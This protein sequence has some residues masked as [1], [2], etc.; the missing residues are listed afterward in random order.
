MLRLRLWLF[1]GVSVVLLVICAPAQA[2][3][4]NE[5]Q[6]A[7]TVDDMGVSLHVPMLMYHSI[8][9]LPPNDKTPFA[10][11]WLDP[12]M[13]RCQM[14]WL[15]QNKYTSITPDQL[16]D[17][18]DGK[19]PLPPNPILLT[20][21]DGYV[22]VWTTVVPTL[23]EFGFTGTFFVITGLL[24]AN[25]GGFISWSEAKIITDLGMSIES[26]SVSHIAMNNKPMDWLSNEADASMKAIEANT[27]KRP[28]AFCYPFGDYDKRAIA[29]VRKAGYELAFTTQD[30]FNA[31]PQNAMVLPRI[32]IRRSTTMNQ[33]VWLITRTVSRLNPAQ[34]SCP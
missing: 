27:G 10:D 16:I 33:F 13:F 25:A 28:H 22:D 4:S 23:K 9:T 30:G 8:S 21:D 6:R 2:R 20:F 29:A 17:A 34:F 3:D 14:R 18:M 1:V 24:D 11:N 31:S 7:A 32:R 26:H 12:K 19:A 5:M 15:Q